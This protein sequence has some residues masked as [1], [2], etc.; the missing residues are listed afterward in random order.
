MPSISRPLQGNAQ[1]LRE[2]LAYGIYGE[3]DTLATEATSALITTQT[4][5]DR[6]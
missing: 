4:Q 3:S 6:Y 2:G 5:D 1:P